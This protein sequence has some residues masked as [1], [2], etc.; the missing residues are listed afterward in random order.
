M[1]ITKLSYKKSLQ[2]VLA[3][4]YTHID[5][6]T[7]S[8]AAI[9]EKNKDKVAVPEDKQTDEQKIAA[10]EEKFALDTIGAVLSALVYAVHPAY[11]ESL[12]LL[13]GNDEFIKA[14]W[15]SHVNALE[16]KLVP[17]DCGCEMCV[18][19]GLVKKG[20]MK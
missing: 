18:K 10:R 5:L 1:R 13:P 19:N 7:R 12:T 9:T 14:C 2:S 17:D 4:S 8:L 16:K 11:E 3:L 6:L 15:Q 20:L